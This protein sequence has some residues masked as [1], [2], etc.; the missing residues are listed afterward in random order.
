MKD[1]CDRTGLPRQVIHFYIQQGLLPEGQK[2]GRNMAYYAESH[3][4]RV[5]LIRQLQHERFLPLKAI[6][7][8]LEEGGDGFTQE[9]RRLLLDVKHR[10]GPILGPPASGRAREERAKRHERRAGVTA[11]EADDLARLGLVRIVR[12]KD[13]TLVAKDGVWMIELWGSLRGAG[14]SRELGFRPE[15]IAL[16]AETMNT[17]FEKEAALLKHR[18]SHLAPDRVARMVELAIPMLNQFMARY[19]EGLVRQFFASIHA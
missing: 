8:V 1:L 5:K 19:H 9:Q 6:R 14:F 3:L 10:L 12:K 15:D 4:E 11:E 16:F 18:L 17:M 2:T 13:R 7:A